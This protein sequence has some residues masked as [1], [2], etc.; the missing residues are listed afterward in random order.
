MIALSMKRSRAGFTLIEIILAITIAVVVLSLAVPALT[1]VPVISFFSCARAPAD[2]SAAVN[3][4]IAKRT[5]FA[6]Q[7][8]WV[9][10][11]LI[12]S[13]MMGRGRVTLAGSDIHALR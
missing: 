11:Y 2:T 1:D 12:P 3:R 13:C 8:A 5:M 7:P 10:A 6:F 4:I 9:P